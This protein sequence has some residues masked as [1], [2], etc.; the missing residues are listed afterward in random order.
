MSTFDEDMKEM[1]TQVTEEVIFHINSTP[2]LYLDLAGKTGKEVKEY[3]FN[4]AQENDNE[5][6]TVFEA[7]L[8]ALNRNDWKA[9]AE[10]I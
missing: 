6:G 5:F 2:K 8:E 7:E 4:H 9:V 1:R 3:V 10:G